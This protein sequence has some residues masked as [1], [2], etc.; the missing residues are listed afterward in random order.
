MDVALYLDGSQGSREKRYRADDL[1]LAFVADK[2][3]AKEHA[4]W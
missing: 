4:Q 2:E 3:V 1:R